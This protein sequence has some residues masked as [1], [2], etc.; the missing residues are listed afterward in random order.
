M[1][2]V[3][4]LDGKKVNGVFRTP[5]GA[6]AVSDASAFKRAMSDKER[7]LNMQNKIDSLTQEIGEIKMMLIQIMA[8]K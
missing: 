4:D 8:N 3:V 2:E 6:L 1:I 5:E 7:I